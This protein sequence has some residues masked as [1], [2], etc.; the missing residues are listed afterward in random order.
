MQFFS[1]LNLENTN[2]HANADQKQEKKSILLGI[3]Q[4]NGGSPSHAFSY[5]QGDWPVRAA[6]RGLT[7]S[8]H[9]RTVSVIG[10]LTASKM[11]SPALNVLNQ[12]NNIRSQKS[13]WKPLGQLSFLSLT[14]NY[15]ILETQT[16]PQMLL[17]NHL[18][19]SYR[20]ERIEKKY[21]PNNWTNSVE[22]KRFENNRK[23]KK[24]EKEKSLYVGVRA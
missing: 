11:S 13:V 6:G 15:L 17:A 4:K 24:Q 2:L 8:L 5:S 21:M 23:L 18:C 12:N 14:T 1:Q 20:N 3:F 7:G 22:I 19:Y 16:T 9:M 10:P